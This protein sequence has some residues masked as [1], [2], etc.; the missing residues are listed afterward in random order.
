MCASQGACEATQE[1]SSVPQISKG[2]MKCL[3]L[4]FLL[5]SFALGYILKS[6]HRARY[7]VALN[8]RSADILNRK[9]RPVFSP[10]HFVVPA[11]CSS[12]SKGRID[13]T[14][15]WGIR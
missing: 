10:E 14:L 7:V 2:I 3:I 12:G 9:V 13:G 11:K 1:Q 5:Q 6:N 15:F 8:D 4:Q